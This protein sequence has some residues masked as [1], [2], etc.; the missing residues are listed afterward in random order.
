MQNNHDK[1][2]KHPLQKGKHIFVTVNIIDGNL[3][4]YHT[5]EVYCNHT[6]H[7]FVPHVLNK[8]LA[9]EPLLY[10]TYTPKKKGLLH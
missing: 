1:F 5:K 4:H 3:F 7:T 9:R 8:K 2:A 10:S 6:R